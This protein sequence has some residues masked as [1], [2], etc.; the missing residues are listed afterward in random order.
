M[1]KLLITNFFIAF[2][3]FTRPTISLQDFDLKNIEL[4][5]CLNETFSD[6]SFLSQ[7]ANKRVI[8]DNNIVN[9]IN[10]KCFKSN[11]RQGKTLEGIYD[12]IEQAKEL[13]NVKGAKFTWD[14]T[15]NNS[16]SLE[17]VF[18][19]RIRDDYEQKPDYMADDFSNFKQ[20]DDDEDIDDS[21]YE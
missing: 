10:T 17:L 8:I 11:K 20:Q 1:E 21:Y 12:A 7:N 6:H 3:L 5:K 16:G 13:L 2:F 18:K 4:I 14:V 9:K 15:I 19:D